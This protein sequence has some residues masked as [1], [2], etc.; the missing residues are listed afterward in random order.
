MVTDSVA[1]YR[2]HPN[3]SPEAVESL[4]TDWRGIPVSDGYGVYQA[5][6]HA[7]QTCLAH[8]LI[9]RARP[10]SRRSQAALAACGRVALKELQRLSQMAQAPPSGGQRQ[11]WHARLRRFARRHEG[12][13]D[14]A[15]RPA[16]RL[17][18]EMGSPWVF[19]GESGV[20]PTNSRAERAL[21]LGVLRRKGSLGTASAKG[22]AWGQRSLSLRQTC[23]Q[24]E[25]SS[26][27]VLADALEAF[28]HDRPPDFSWLR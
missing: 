20:E 1:L 26:F 6:G 12:R 27:S 5:R 17:R 23:R 7:R 3:R 28:M 24:L 9:R 2:I 11:A 14:D 13:P 15:G 18:H 22:N 16:R 21:R 4:I 10:L 25:H 19:R 8:P